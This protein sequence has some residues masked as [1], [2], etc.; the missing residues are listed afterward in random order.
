[1][2]LSEV[3]VKKA[4]ASLSPGLFSSR[5]APVIIPYGPHAWGNR[6][7]GWMGRSMADSTVRNVTMDMR[8]K[9]MATSSPKKTEKPVA[10]SPNESET[11]GNATVSSSTGTGTAIEEATYAK[12]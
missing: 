8:K 4:L 6:I 10:A 2:P 1:M 5:P 12:A 7:M 9:K 3:W 11:N